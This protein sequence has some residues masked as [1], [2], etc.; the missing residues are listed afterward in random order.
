MSEAIEFFSNS[1]IA[2]TK[3][4]LLRENYEKHLGWEAITVSIFSPAIVDD[5]EIIIRLWYVPI[6]VELDTGQLRPTAFNDA[7]DKGLSVN[8]SDYASIEEIQEAAIAQALAISKIRSPRDYHGYSTAK[9]SQIR[10]QMAYDLNV[11]AVYDTSLDFEEG[12]SH[13]DVCAIIPHATDKDLTKNGYK[14]LVRGRLYK[15]FSNITNS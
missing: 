11:F 3:C 10:A 13:A 1:D 15:C 9:V 4:S 6:H 12:I 14:R 8:R 5:D 2:Q 7:I